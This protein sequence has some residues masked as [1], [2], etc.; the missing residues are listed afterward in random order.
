MKKL[1][2]FLAIAIAFIANMSAQTNPAGNSLKGKSIAV[3]GDSYVQNHRESYTK[4]WHYKF[5]TKY[6]MRYQNFGLNGN[7]VSIDTEQFGPAM[8]KRYTV[9][10]DT[11]DY[12]IIVAGHNDAGRL[13]RITPKVYE[14]KATLLC[15]LLKERYPN[16][17]MAW[18]TPWR[19][20]G[21]YGGNFQTVADI[22]AKVCQEFGIPVF[23]SAADYTIK[24][25]SDEFRSKYFQNKGINDRAHLNDEGH[26]LFEPIAEQ[27]LLHAWGIK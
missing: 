9:L 25:D 13:D 5:A 24:A 11:L 6:G 27:F 15:R 23:N 7:C 1:T 17:K 16:T 18:F 8:Y 22:T 19:V 2:L 21:Y 20:K 14:E 3:F 10:P 4:T 12:L 26:D